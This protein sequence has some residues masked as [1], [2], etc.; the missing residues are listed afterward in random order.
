MGIRSYQDLDVW[1]LSVEL[2]MQA[3]LL[4]DGL[5]SMRRYAMA[6]QL[7]YSE[8]PYPYRRILPKA[9]AECT[10]QSTRITFR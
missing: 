9:T 5:V 3:D 1:K 2:A 4:A 6:N 7:S 10:G 8:P